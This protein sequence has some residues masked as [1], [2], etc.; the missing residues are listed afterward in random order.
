MRCS[1]INCAN[2]P[3]EPYYIVVS[4]DGDF[5]C[6]KTCQIEYLNQRDHFFN[7]TIH[8][9]EATNRFLMGS[10]DG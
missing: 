5:V 3:S 8:S 9:E 10:T 6:N 7:V 2:I 1:N 4:C